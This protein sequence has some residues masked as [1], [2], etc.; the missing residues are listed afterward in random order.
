MTRFHALL[1]GV[2][3]P[4]GQ[5]ILKR[6]SD[7]FPMLK[8]VVP[9]APYPEGISL[10]PYFIP[11]NLRSATQMAT[12]FSRVQV[13]IICHSGYN[14]GPIRGAIAD[15]NIPFIDAG[16]PGPDTV[17]EAAMHNFHFTPT[18]LDGYQGA[19]GIGLTG[20]WTIAHQPRRIPYPR[21][22]H[23]LWTIEQES[24]LCSEK[25][26]AR[27]RI[28]FQNRFFSLFFWFTAMFLRYLFPFFREGKP[29]GSV[30]DWRFNGETVEH[31]QTYEFT[32]TC[33]EL[34]PEILAP[35]LAIVKLLQLLK[36]REGGGE[37]R[38]FARFQI[39]LRSYNK[40]S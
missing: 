5:L 9:T 25:V 10:P 11:L 7:H 15:A 12:A 20:L 2:D 6:L 19:S 38:P 1:F 29:L 17:L 24:V 35:D 23:E 27:H 34:N 26:S 14:T 40:V 4:N 39:K 31:G 16:S 18:E 13:V 36:I 37:W 33:D 8:I 22:I 3:T 28:Q 30:N 21:L 32:A